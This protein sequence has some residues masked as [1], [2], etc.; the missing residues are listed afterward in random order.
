MSTTDGSPPTDH[1][2]HRAVVERVV[3]FGVAELI[4]DPARAQGW[5]VA[6]DGVAQSY[7]W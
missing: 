4:P 3:D 1:E 5:T 2:R 6:V 7:V